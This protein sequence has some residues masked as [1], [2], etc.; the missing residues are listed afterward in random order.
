MEKLE[1]NFATCISAREFALFGTVEALF[2]F[3]NVCLRRAMEWRK[4]TRK[5][6]S[7]TFET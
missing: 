3:I 4:Q 6:I 2:C 1:T 5:E 7:K